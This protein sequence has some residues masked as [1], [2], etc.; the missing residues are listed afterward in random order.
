MKKT[1]A[2]TLITTILVL[3]AVLYFTKY[4]ES[5]TRY[6]PLM[7]NTTKIIER[8]SQ[9]RIHLLKSLDLEKGAVMAVTDEESKALAEQSRLSAEAVDREY[10]ELKDLLDRA[11]ID[12]ETGL[13]NEFHTAWEE[14]RLIDRELLSLAGENTN[15]K[16]V[17]LSNGTAL[18]ELQH[19][20][21]ALSVLM[22]IPPLERDRLRAARLAYQAATAAFMIYS[23]ESTHINEA[24]DVRMDE[25]EKIMGLNEQKVR[26]RLQ[27]IAALIGGGDGSAD[28]NASSSFSKFMEMHKEIIRLSRLNSNIKS[29]QLSLGRKR[30]IA[31]Q[32][33]EILNALEDVVQQRRF[34]ATR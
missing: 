11:A 33:E 22:D 23:L 2:I 12:K 31:A 32:C 16:A 15:I 29:L 19:F 10:K 27:Q 7:I 21:R 3:G 17:H 1:V 8:I 9:M 6:M 25:L 20:E 5:R 26:N 30:R 24:Q 28:I 34:K 14:L 18:Q 4:H 13:L